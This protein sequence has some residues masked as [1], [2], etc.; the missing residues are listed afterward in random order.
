MYS[1]PSVK[2]HSRILLD[3]WDLP[4]CNHNDQQKGAWCV[5]SL[6]GKS[7]EQ[8]SAVSFLLVTTQY[9]H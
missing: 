7:T 4:F 6:F 9:W 2:E 5:Q 3:S 8:L 1:W